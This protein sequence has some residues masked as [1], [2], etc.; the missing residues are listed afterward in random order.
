[1][2]TGNKLPLLKSSFKELVNHLRDEDRLAIVTYA[3]NPGVALESTPCSEKTKIKN[4]IDLLDAGGSTNGSGG[5]EAAYEI[6]EQHFSPSGNNRIIIASDGDFNVGVTE[7]ESLLDLIEE[8]REK[9]IFLTTIGVG[10]GNYND[11]NMEQIANHGNGTYEY[12]DDLNQGIKVFVDEFSKFYT[13]A[14]DVKVQVVFNPRLVHAYRLI[15]YENR[16]LENEDFE[17]DTKD[18]GE[19][20][21]GQA[22]TALYEFIP[23]DQGVNPLYEP[24]FSIE[25]R[26]KLPNEDQS[27]LMELSVKDYLN[28]FE[29]SS[30]N[31]QFASSMAALGMYLFDS[32]HKGEIT[33]QKIKDWVKNADDYDPNGYKQDLRDLLDKI[34]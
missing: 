31:M 20:G 8:K 19:I 23:E 6:A 30:E 25:F 9:G 17:D 15:G 18:A 2:S 16:L 34:N 29:Q 21:A 33:L 1:M 5:I 24:T 10:R 14:K 11:A 27:Q 22:I 4:A 28:S 3:S 26:Y 13:V 12:I 7:H 32:K